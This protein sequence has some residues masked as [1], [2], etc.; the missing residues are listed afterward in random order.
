MRRASSRPEMTS[1][2]WPR[3]DWAR[4]RKA[5][6]LLRLAQRL[7][8]DRA[9]LARA[10]KPSSRAGEAGQAG[11]AARG[12]LV[13]EQAGGVEPGAEAHRF[14][15]VVDA[16]VAAVDELADLEPEAVRAHVDR[17]ELAGPAAVAV[18][19]AR[20][21]SKPSGRLCGSGVTGRRRRGLP[22]MQSAFD[23]CQDPSCCAPISIPVPRLRA[24]RA[25]G[26]AASPRAVLPVTATRDHDRQRRPRG[27]RGDDR[28]ERLRDA[29]LPGDAGRR[30][31]TCRSSSSSPRSSACTSTSPTSRG[32]SPGRLPGDRARAVRAPGR[33]QALRRHRQAV[34]DRSSPRCPTRR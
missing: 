11:E 17:G 32:A 28:F 14:L 6:R 19:R 33:R 13:A 34:R 9:H 2:G 15:Q 1:I 16:P 24:I 25:A 29:G 20:S 4:A 27:R 12:R 30:G 26:H 5:S 22:R 23:R 10:A 7:R 31:A 3:A 21:D 18:G 8:R